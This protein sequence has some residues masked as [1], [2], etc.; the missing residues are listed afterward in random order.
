VTAKVDR[1]LDP[2]MEIQIFI[3]NEVPSFQRRKKSILRLIVFE[4]VI[5]RPTTVA[6]LSDLSIKKTMIPSRAV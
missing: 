6:R 5:Y 2:D 3:I 1:A 4:M